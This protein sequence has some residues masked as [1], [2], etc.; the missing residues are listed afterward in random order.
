MG[1]DVARRRLPLV[2]D[3][4]G[5]WS[6]IHVDDAARATVAALSGPAGT[7]NIV[8]DHPAKVAEWLP[9]FARALGAPAPRR[10]P[11]WLARRFAGE[12]GVRSMTAAQGASGAR[13]R[14]ELGFVPDFSDWREGFARGLR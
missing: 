12:Y 14:S 2:G 7:Y 5:V 11:V 13:A 1:V 8:D 4:A 10:V 6:L 3:G 9:Q